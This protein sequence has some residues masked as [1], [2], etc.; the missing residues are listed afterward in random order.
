LI[1]ERSS[2]IL[3]SVTDMSRLRIEHWLYSAP[4]WLRSLFRRRRVEQELDEEFAYHVERK[5]E[6]FIAQGLTPEEARRAARRSIDGLTQRKE[7]CREA[8]RTN[9]IDN[10]VRDI[11]YSLR[12]LAKS[13]GFTVVAVATLALAI[14]AN[15]VVFGIVNGLVL[16]PLNVP[17]GTRVRGIERDKV[18]GYTSYP[19][20]IDV[21]DRNRSFES[22]A[23]YNIDGAGLDT[24]S[25]DPIAAPLYE[26]S[27]NYFDTLGVQPYLGRVVHASDER[28][29]NS[30]PYIVLTYAFWQAHFQGDRGVIG[31]V[32]RLN[33]H[34]FT[35]VGVTPPDFHGTLLFFS[36]SLFVP[37][38]NHQQIGD[39]N[40]LDVRARRW[41][42][43]TFGLLKPGVTPA[44]AATDLNSIGAWLATTYPK[45][46]REM[47]YFLARPDLPGID[48]AA[49]AFVAALM[50][51]AGLILLA[52]CANLG[53]LFAARAADRAREV[54]LRLALG[55]SRARI[56]RGLFTEALLIAIAGGTAGLLGSVALL[57]ALSTWRP[58]PRFPIQVPV[59]PDASVYVV[60]LALALASGFLFGIVPVRQ[61]LR[62]DPY[63][64]VKAGSASTP[65]R[66]LTMRDALLVAQ[67]AICAV[68]VTSSMV[69]MRGLARSIN[70]DFGFEPENA[71]LVDTNLFAAGYSGEARPAM[72]KRMRE[73]V[74][75][76]P[77]V[78]AAGVIDNPPLVEG[79]TNTTVFTDQTTDLRPAN[80][81]AEV[82]IYAMSP[83]YFE[84][85]G[86]R[87]LMGRNIDA[88]DDGNSPRVAVV[89]REFA[90][91]VFGS[92]GN[93]IGHFFKRRDGTRIQVV[94]ITGDGK[95]TTYVAE[96]RQPVMFLS[97]AQSPS[98]ETWLVVRSER[99]A[100]QLATAIRRA[101]RDV[102]A[103]LPLYMETWRK[104]M[105]GALFAGRVATVSLGVLGAMGAVLALTGIFG[106]AAYSVSR[107]LKE[108]G[109]RLALG[110][111]KREMLGAALGRAVRLLAVGSAVGLALGIL[112]SRL[113]AYIV[114][115][116]TPRDPV[117]L[118][119][120]VAAMAL[121]GLVAT[122]IP[123]QRA[124]S[125]DPV[126]LLREE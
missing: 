29:P 37:I 9:G 44:Q 23:A 20:Y 49:K 120:V 76:I 122:W 52:A 33:R 71:M 116:A 3:I 83:E 14:G 66:R 88:H 36:P 46:D 12:V 39:D 68:L 34:P 54:A 110:A 72:Q 48:S 45:E 32:V 69:A 58:I 64:I 78:R 79:W 51:L 85:A 63:Q 105:D 89:N 81:V 70:A 98:S 118:G 62:T 22:I 74:A 56:L 104:G 57:R 21:R 65:G 40:G 6:E 125:L 124:L 75:A 87:L 67:I 25:G 91:R 16:R 123:A 17:N 102:D 38:V 90:R 108:L 53:N 61:V 27:G 13:P 43:D 97:L 2:D 15:A 4:L 92:A 10:T 7:E 93:A 112:A 115:Q 119:G 94:G 60:A 19:D 50:L 107:R 47:R 5:T 121:L 1:T 86:T 95:Y 80:A 113:L 101:I 42:F 41:V 77:G 8:R 111:R 73:A 106:M 24:G 96:D 100:Q 28:G 114:Y 117:V 55:A 99:D 26:V 30:A 31:R 82:V 103:G 84:A 18:W 35:I 126:R 109:I 59:Q 11:R